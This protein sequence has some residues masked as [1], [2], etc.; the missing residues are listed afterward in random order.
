MVDGGAFRTFFDGRAESDSRPDII[1]EPPQSSRSVRMDQESVFARIARGDAFAVKECMQRFGGLVWSLARRWSDNAADAEDA[2]QEIF[3]ELWKFAHRYDATAG[4]EES[5]VATIARRRLID[6]LRSRNRRPPTESFDEELMVDPSDDP[7]AA[8]FASAEVDV[9]QRA[10]ARLDD[11][12]R[13]VLLMGI[14][15]GM[16]HSEI[17]TATGRPLGTVK[18]QMRRGLIKVRELIE[19]GGGDRED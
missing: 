7:S 3:V 2:A 4:S 10:L 12:Q 13:Q 9:A 14:V 18:T 6:K 11:A 19:A 15:E 8:N 1:E 5:F 17:A 16:T